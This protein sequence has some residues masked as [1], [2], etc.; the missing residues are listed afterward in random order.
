MIVYNGKN[1]DLINVIVVLFFQIKIEN[2]ECKDIAYMYRKASI[3][4]KYFKRFEANFNNLGF[5]QNFIRK[6]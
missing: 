4:Y 6:I 5:L 1:D 2:A 3:M